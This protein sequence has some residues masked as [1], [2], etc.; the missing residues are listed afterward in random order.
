MIAETYQEQQQMQEEAPSAY[1][2]AKVYSVSENGIQLIFPGSD[3]PSSKK[4]NYNAAVSFSA[5]Q[6]VCVMKDSGTYIVM[7]PLKW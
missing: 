3:T 2:I 4:Y 7:F 6:R 5:G 1:T